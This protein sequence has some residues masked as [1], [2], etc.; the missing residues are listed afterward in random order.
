MGLPIP[1]L[2]EPSALP[3]QRHPRQTLHHVWAPKLGRTLML[4]GRD[5]LHLWVMLEA[6]P[7]VTRYCERPSAHDASGP[8]PAADF[9]ALRD[10]T[11]VWL[12]LASNESESTGDPPIQTVAAADLQRHRQ[13]IANWLSLLPYLSSASPLGLGPLQAEVLDFVGPEARLDEIE[14]HFSRTDPVLVRTAV[15]ATLHDGRLISQDLQSAPWHL[16]MRL[17]PTPRFRAGSPHAPQ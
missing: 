2:T 11:P 15:I 6:H 3:V 17:R 7:G 14:H 5:Q 16:G 8:G 10:G 9:W 13:W 4:T 1:V 12:R